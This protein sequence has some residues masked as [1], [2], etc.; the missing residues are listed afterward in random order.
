MIL[1]VYVI[2]SLHEVLNLKSET[3]NQAIAFCA[4]KTK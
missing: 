4:I 3:W 1:M 2:V